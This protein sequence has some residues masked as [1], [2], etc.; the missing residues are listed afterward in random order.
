MFRILFTK[1]W[2]ILTVILLALIPAFVELG[3]W[4]FHRYQ[5]T[6]RNNALISANIDPHRVTP[7]AGL[8]RPGGSVPDA[9]LYRNVTVSGH[10]VP[11]DEFVIRQ[12]TDSSGD[13]IGF[14]VVTPLETAGGD[15]VLVN[16]GW[17][18]PNNSDGTTYP[19]SVPPAPTGTVTLTGRLRPDETAKSTGIRDRSGLPPRQFQLINSQQQTSRL[20]RRIYAGYI[21]LTATSPTP[22][23]RDLA[24]QVPP[25]TAQNDS[26]AV[27]GKGVHLPYAIQ[28]WVFAAL[29]PVAWILLFRREVREQT[30][31]PAK[32]PRPGTAPPGG[33]PRPD[34]TPAAA[35]PAPRKADAG[36]EAG[37]AG[38]PS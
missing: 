31:G 23:A 21:E 8:S 24:Q 4:Q 20:H 32:R 27:V 2:L 29:V 5:Q 1:R 3:M 9:D 18:A 36:A 12:R 30:A 15:L 26:M 37:T 22:P 6:N 11:A 10:Y 33:G 14:Y 13:N 17:V 34:R 35:A 16:R 28:W 7:L 38:D 25:P 19:T